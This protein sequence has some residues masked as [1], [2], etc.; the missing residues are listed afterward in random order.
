MLKRN[1]C[2]Y[3]IKMRAELKQPLNTRLVVVGGAQAHG[4]PNACK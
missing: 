2:P 1:E 3:V 4:R